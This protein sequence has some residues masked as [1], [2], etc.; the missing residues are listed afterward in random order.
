MRRRPAWIPTLAAFAATVLFV[1]AGNWQHRRMNE[2]E[3]LQAQFRAAAAA[4]PVPLPDGVDWRTWRFR[5]VIVTGRFDGV[6][7]ILIDNKVHDG[8]AGF[9][10]VTP[11]T[12]DDARVVLVDRGWTPVGRTRATLPDIPPP[13]GIVTIH[14]RVD[15]PGREYLELGDRSAPAGPLWEHLD[16]ERF[17]AATGL[18]VLP[19]VVLAQDAPGGDKLVRDRGLP[20]AG[21]EKHLSYMLQ[22]YTFAAMAAG[23]WLWFTLRPWV[24]RRAR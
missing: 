19:I 17:A 5:S 21:I 20:D 10:V 3:A 18:A 24:L 14:G 13:R 1:L 16:P 23:L 4:V 7:Q 12:L 2:K 8:T 22:W 6:R 9:D 15:I 11:L